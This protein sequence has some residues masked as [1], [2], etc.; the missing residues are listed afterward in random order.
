MAPVSFSALFDLINDGG[1]LE[2]NPR[3]GRRILYQYV[4]PSRSSF[5]GPL[6]QAAAWPA[7]PDPVGEMLAKAVNRR[8]Q[9]EHSLDGSPLQ[10][11]PPP[12]DPSASWP[13]RRFAFPLPTR[14]LPSFD[15]WISER[16]VEARE[17][18]LVQ[19]EHDASTSTRDFQSPATP[20]NVW[21]LFLF[22]HQAKAQ[23]HG[24]VRMR[25]KSITHRPRS[26]T[27]FTI[28]RSLVRL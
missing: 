27:G 23:T 28:C 3:G 26:A 19:C 11:P 17:F 6:Y 8:V 18:A 2:T 4:H 12:M 25:Q 24:L 14:P 13:L 5:A 1:L 9:A 15:L 22:K 16:S 10:S 7:Q 21:L 20:C